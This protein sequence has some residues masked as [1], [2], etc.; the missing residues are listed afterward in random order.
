VGYGY[1]TWLAGAWIAALAFV[2]SFVFAAAYPAHMHQSAT[3]VPKFNPLVYTLDVL[4]PI[5]D[6][7]QQKAW[8]AQGGAQIW[9][10]VLICAGWLLTTAVVAGLT[11]ALTRTK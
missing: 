9:S 10:W 7:D 8:I 6:L 11:S 2:G 1:R 3:V 5:V 4:L